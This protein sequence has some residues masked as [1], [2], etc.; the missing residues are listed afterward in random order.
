MHVTLR[1]TTNTLFVNVFTWRINIRQKFQQNSHAKSTAFS[2]NTLFNA[3]SEKLRLHGYTI[4]DSDKLKS[5]S[6]IPSKFDGRIFVSRLCV[7]KLKTVYECTSFF[8]CENNYSVFCIK[9]LFLKGGKVSCAKAG[10]NNHTTLLQEDFMT[11]LKKVL[12]L[13]RELI[14]S[15]IKEV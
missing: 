15:L 1:K 10:V 12:K 14:D 5:E 2:S 4:L 3:T 9:I 11:R 6:K 13:V 8:R 7:A